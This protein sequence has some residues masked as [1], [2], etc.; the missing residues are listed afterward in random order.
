MRKYR[1]ASKPP[2]TKD[3]MLPEDTLESLYLGVKFPNI[4]G[5]V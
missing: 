5:G 3:Y 1:Q 4:F 2:P